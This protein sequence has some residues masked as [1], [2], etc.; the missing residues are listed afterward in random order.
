MKYSL[1]SFYRD[2]IKEKILKDYLKIGII[3]ST[4]QID[5]ALNKIIIESNEFNSPL[6]GTTDFYVENGE[7]SSAKKT[8]KIYE[9]IESDL[10]VSV[11]ALLDQENKISNL[12]DTYFNKLTGLQKRINLIKEQVDNVL[13][14]SKNT[15]THEA[16]FYEKFS[17]LDMVDQLLTSCSVD[18]NV[19]EVTLKATTQNPID[20]S[21]SVSTITIVPE[22]NPKIT[23][24]NDIGEM[25]VNNIVNNSNKVWMHQI[26]ATE[27]LS[28]VYLD[29][30]L[31]V[32][33]VTTEI[34][35]IVLE[36][37]SVDIKTQINIEISIS[38]DGLNWTYPDG[39]YKKR[40]EKVTSFSFSGVTNEYW[41]IRF[42]KFGSDGFF[43]NSYVYN[44]G[45][46]SL[47][48]LGKVYDK[49]SRLDLGYFYSKP[50]IFNKDIK[51]ANVKVCENL[52]SQSLITYF[53]APIYSSLLPSITSGS[54][55]A[56]DLYYYPLDLVDKDSATLDF[57]NTSA[58]P[59][60]SGIAIN[61]ALSYK[62][63]G[64]YDYCLD[65]ILPLDYVKEETTVLRDS[66]NQN[67]Y[68]LIGIEK[69]FSDQP[70]G[71]KFDGN[72]YYTYQL[73]E[74]HNGLEIDLGST[75]MYI[76]NVKV[77]GRV[78][79]PKGLNFIVTHRDNWKSLDLS[80]LPLESDQSVD[81]L[82]PFNHKYLIEGLSDE[83]YG[84]DLNQIIDG[85]KL[86]DII[87]NNKVYPRSSK[88]CWSIKMKEL[89]FDKFVS[90]EKN[91]LDVF[92]Y[93]I[94][95][96][97]QERIVV[98]SD[99]D[100]GLINNETFSIITKLH[101]AEKIKGLIF[102]AVMETEN[103]KVSPTLT[104]YLVKVK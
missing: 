24:S 12:Y 27:P 66:L 41:R 36:P 19:R 47:N 29:L 1:S 69:L 40:F 6:L 75:Q 80:T 44:Y 43:S 93:K 26:S 83:L 62:D 49:V 54:I 25:I 73:I 90:K 59:V 89:S 87:D 48:F 101:S 56:K 9:L 14:E 11:S 53:I 61:D 67:N 32:P 8:N 70:I 28:S 68:N 84:V 60:I 34:N 94:D 64:I 22:N 31:R 4:N 13:F 100:N 102:K 97:N 52:P 88:K 79:I 92:A 81:P 10:T 45:L 96:T 30:I 74:D 16:L 51:I 15:D 20:L 77:Q 82:Y 104:E 18:T 17:S 85:E 99:S 76:N 57:L 42:T 86:I 46:K 72:Y 5:E 65:L 21:G 50:L 37:F 3:P 63:K 78:I 103:N 95:N 2:F 7:L 58:N 91:E 38:K 33:S 98:K 35:K 55:S 39:E 71:W 23:S